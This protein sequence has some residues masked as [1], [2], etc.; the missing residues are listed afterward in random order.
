[1]DYAEQQTDIEVAKVEK[2]LSDVYK[3]AN[4]ELQQI[5]NDYFSKFAERYEKEY[6]AFLQGK[7]TAQEF[8]MWYYT[9]VGR[10]ERWQT[11]KTD[12]AKKMVSLNQEAAAYINSKTPGIYALNANFTAYEIEKKSGIA[13][14]IVSDD[15]VRELALDKNH[16][17]FRVLSVNPKRDYEWNQKRIQ[18]EL[19]SGILQ[20]KSIDRL[21]DGFLNV[22]GSNRGAAIR[23]A[24]TALTSAQNAGRQNTFNRAEELGIEVEKEWIAT[25]DN[26]TRDS[27]KRLD[28]VIVKNNEE[29][30]NG[31]M[32][33]GDPDGEPEEIWN[34]RCSMR[35]ILPKYGD[36]SRTGNTAAEYKKWVEEKNKSTKSQERGI[37]QSR[38][39]A[40]GLRTSPSHILTDEEI[41]S[42]IKD[43][44]SI[45]IPIDVLKFNEGN[46]TGFSELTGKI[47]VRG[48]VLPD[49]SSFQNRDTM[50][51]RA[52]LAH[53]YYGHYMNDPSEYSVGDW[54]D[55]YRASRDAALKTPNLLE[56]ERASLMIDAYERAREAGQIIEYDDIAK[57]VIYG[58]VF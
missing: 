8:K 20:G 22:M 26:R 53:E 2:H 23:N 10:G 17:E 58:K 1:M 46:R 56:I 36:K 43:A 24:R 31:L 51:S 14:N 4:K 13:F 41:K 34:C 18:N 25:A 47:N 50:T 3:N 39:M 45:G 44:E 21:A 11:I 6:D 35:S 16:S 28:G 29:F 15:V 48:D 12:M 52:V 9:Q 42:L 19:L 38:G 30:P 27:H 54:R 57:E 5:T 40:L 55:E 37:I 49:V 32:Y 7:Y 33:P